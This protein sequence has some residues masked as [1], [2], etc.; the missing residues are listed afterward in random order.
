MKQ[1][2]ALYVFLYSYEVRYLER[3]CENLKILFMT[4]LSVPISEGC[5]VNKYGESNQVAMMPMM[6]QIKPY[7]SMTSV[8]HMKHFFRLSWKP[9]SDRQILPKI[10]P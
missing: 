3:Q 2:C 4:I 6:S 9:F 7:T 8:L 1:W 5:W 10:V